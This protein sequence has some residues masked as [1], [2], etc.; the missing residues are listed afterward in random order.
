MEVAAIPVPTVTRATAKAVKTPWGPLP[1]NL[2]FMAFVMYRD[3]VMDAID[4]LVRNRFMLCAD[5]AGVYARLLQ[6]GLDA[7]VPAPKGNP[8]PQD[9]VPSCEPKGKGR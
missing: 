4:N 1:E 2:R 5:T 6:A 9:Q 8:I 7:G 3:A